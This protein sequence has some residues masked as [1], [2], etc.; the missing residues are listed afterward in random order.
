M[1]K[2]LCVFMSA[3][4]LLVFA[5]CSASDMKGEIHNAPFYDFSILDEETIL[6]G[7]TQNESYSEIIQNTFLPTEEVSSQA[8]SLKVDTAAYSNI[9]RYINNGTLPPVDAVRTEELINYFDYDEKIDVN[10][11]HPFGVKAQVYPSPFVSGKHMAYVRVRTPDMDR[12]QLPPS[13]L[14]FLI[15]T[16]GSMA[17]YNK[18][19][20]LQRAF[21]LLVEN[22]NENDV[23]SIVTYCF[24]NI[25][26][27]IKNVESMKVLIIIIGLF[28]LFISAFI[29]MFEPVAP[30]L[31]FSRVLQAI[32]IMRIPIKAR[33]GACGKSLWNTLIITAP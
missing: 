28:V 30:K 19:G 27:K 17:S 18:L 13:N 22:L 4:L 24:E 6:G 16:S 1:K 3:C 29:R 33:I 5:S 31:A 9:A 7:G 15:D 23:V 21:E 8:F 14:T 20:L 26:A 12:S 2:I 10:E 32:G 11:E 25:K